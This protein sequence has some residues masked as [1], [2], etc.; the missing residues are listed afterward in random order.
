MWLV[1]GLAGR[2]ARHVMSVLESDSTS[3]LLTEQVPLLSVLLL[4]ATAEDV[5]S[6]AAAAALFSRLLQQPA[7]TAAAEDDAA[8]REPSAAA[9]A[10]PLTLEQLAVLQTLLTDVW[11]EGSAL[12]TALAAATEEA[13]HGAAVAEDAG[14]QEQQQQQQQ[15]NEEE[16]QQEQQELADSLGLPASSCCLSQL[17]SCW[18]QLLSCMLAQGHVAGVLAVLDK[19]AAAAATVAMTAAAAAA[20]AGTQADLQQQQQQQQQQQSPHLVLPI[21]EAEGQELLDQVTAHASSS[22][23]SSSS[24]EAGGSQLAAVLGLLMPFRSLQECAVAQLVQGQVLV[25]ADATYSKQLLAL[26]LLRGQLVQ[27]AGTGVA[28]AAEPGVGGEGSAAAAA[29]GQMQAYEMYKLLLAESLTAGAAGALHQHGQ[30]QLGLVVGCL[31]PHAVAQLCLGS[32]YTSAA[33]LVAARARVA[34]GMCTLQGALLVLERYLAFVMHSQQQQQ[35]F[36]RAAGAAGAGVGLP[37]CEHWLAS[38]TAAAAHT[39]HTKLVQALCSNEGQQQGG[40]AAGGRV[41]SLD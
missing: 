16:Q 14:S 11:R 24:G 33:A 9:A 36:G 29:A 40:R 26:L 4:Q 20:A 31:L 21:S 28:A 13:A 23:S 1:D 25:P 3:K 7:S 15:Q 41:S 12:P 34:S 6:V 2:A 35:H 5:S 37:C 39:A 17:H 10:T 22:N 38:T 18:Q 8:A 19:V 30:Q 32:D 27:L